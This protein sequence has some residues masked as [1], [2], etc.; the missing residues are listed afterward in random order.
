MGWLKAHEHWQNAC[1]AE[2]RCCWLFNGQHQY[3]E[4]ASRYHSRCISIPTHV[5]VCLACIHTQ[6]H[7]HACTH[8]RLPFD[9]SRDG[10]ISSSSL[11]NFSHTCHKIRLSPAAHWEYQRHVK[12]FRG[13]SHARDEATGISSTHTAPQCCR[14]ASAA[15]HDA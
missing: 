5:K 1:S 7:A 14:P 8:A 10:E 4:A 9:R 12:G 15:R 6:I 2:P 3:Q 11:Y 13:V